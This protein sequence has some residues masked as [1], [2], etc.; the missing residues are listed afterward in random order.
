MAHDSNVAPNLQPPGMVLLAAVL[1]VLQDKP[2]LERLAEY[3]HTGRPGY[4][5]KAMWRAYVASF[6]L[7]LGSTNDLIRRLQD[8]PALRELCGLDRLPHRTTFNRFI[9]RLSWHRDLVECSAASLTAKL[10]EALP[11]FGDI[12]AVDSTFVRTHANPNRK[13]LSDPEASWTA[14]NS[15]GAKNGKL[16][17]YGFKWHAAADT[18]YGIPIV[19]ITTTAGPHDVKQFAPVLDYAAAQHLWFRPAFVVADKAYDA[20]ATTAKVLE[21]GARPII[22]AIRRRYKIDGVYYADGTPACYWNDHRMEFVSSDPLEGQFFQCTTCVHSGRVR[23][24]K[25]KENPRLFADPPRASVEWRALYSQRQAVERVFK[26]MKQSLR[27][28][29]HSVRGLRQ[30]ALHTAMSALTFAA[31][32]LVHHQADKPERIRWMVR[33]VA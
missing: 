15:A 24:E 21:L 19:G 20:N 7:N 28:E 10:R 6:A 16:Y 4:P 9:Q 26:S 29:A 31:K 25:L 12:V 30:V 11:G 33:K 27:L 1:G 32:A 3:R 13:H 23:P 14:K 17:S 2:I 22:P 18:T 8:D 5:V